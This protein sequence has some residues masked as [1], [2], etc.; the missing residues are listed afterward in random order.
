MNTSIFFKDAFSI[1]DPE[2]HIYTSVLT[3][4]IKFCISTSFYVMMVQ[5][6]EIYPT[7]L[8]QTGIALGVLS[9]NALGV[10]GPYVV[11]L[12]IKQYYY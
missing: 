5:G 2:L 4:L 3:V 1:P 6:V 7:C 11:Y 10:V 12:V 9:G 8:R